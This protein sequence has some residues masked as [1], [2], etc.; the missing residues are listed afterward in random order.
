MLVHFLAQSFPIHA[1]RGF[2]LRGLHRRAHLRF[3]GRAGFGD[4]LLHERG[5]VL[6]ARP[7]VT[8]TPTCAMSVGHQPGQTR[9]VIGYAVLRP[10]RQFLCEPVGQRNAV[11]CQAARRTGDG[12]RASK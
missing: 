6:R 12:R 11:W 10:R 3:R 8:D 9:D 7:A 5:N 4:R 1:A 2:R